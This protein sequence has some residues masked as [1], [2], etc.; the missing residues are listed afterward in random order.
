MTQKIQNREKVS[1]WHM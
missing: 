1:Y